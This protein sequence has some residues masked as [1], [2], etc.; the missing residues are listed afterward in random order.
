MKKKEVKT[1]KC[2]WCEKRKL[3]KN[4][5]NLSFIGEGKIVKEVYICVECN[6]ELDIV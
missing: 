1:K 3:K 5:Y 6:I 4:M 2:N